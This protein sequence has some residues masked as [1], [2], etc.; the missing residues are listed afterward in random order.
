MKIL[1]ST[2]FR[3]F[4][5]PLERVNQLNFLNSI[6][7][8]SN[9]IDLCVTQ[10]GEKNVK[11][12][13]NNN[14]NGKIIYQNINNNKFKWSHSE[15]FK[16]ALKKF[17]L[18]KYD[19]IAW[20]S[21]DIIIDKKCFYELKNKNSR[22]MFTFFPNISN[23]KKNLVEFG[24]DIFFFKINKFEAKKMLKILSKFPNYDWG[25][26]E[27]YLFS[28]SEILKLNRINLR[29]KCKIYKN[30]NL[31]VKNR[32]IINIES[33]KKNKNIL[34]KMLIK[35]KIS[36]L[37]ANGSMYFLAFK[38]LNI[39]NLNSELIIIYLKLS[40]KFLLRIINGKSY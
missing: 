20:C 19:Y 8:H 7:N 5:K 23:R 36:L 18:S 21:S 25:M 28:F 11:K 13:I 37:Y 24:L 22:S 40:L 4:D 14:F 6:N 2:T 1:L 9:Q 27:H 17:L 33:W 34:E 32:N 35:N 3:S 31:K 10:F 26:F 30:E 29:T 15:V 38:L 12:Y 16:F 39:K